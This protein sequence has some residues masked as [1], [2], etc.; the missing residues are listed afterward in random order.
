M[1]LTMKKLRVIGHAKYMGSIYKIEPARGRRALEREGISGKYLTI[2]FYIFLI[3]NRSQK[4][5]YRASSIVYP[6]SGFCL[7]DSVFC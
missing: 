1:C 2:S 5:E 7:L 4:I 6:V 3:I